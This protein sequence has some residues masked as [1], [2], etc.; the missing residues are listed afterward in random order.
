M[1]LKCWEELEKHQKRQVDTALIKIPSWKQIFNASS[2]KAHQ[3][4]FIPEEYFNGFFFV[5]Q[6]MC[7]R[8]HDHMQSSLIS[9]VFPV[10]FFCR[11]VGNKVICCRG[12]CQLLYDCIQI[13]CRYFIYYIFPIKFVPHEAMVFM[14]AM[15]WRL[16]FRSSK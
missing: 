12:V 13:R 14:V 5:R 16:S 15:K 1:R 7:H 10:L 3:Y 2:K 6:G 4:D 9:Q 8:H 11:I